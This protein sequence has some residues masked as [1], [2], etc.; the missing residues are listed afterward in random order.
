LLRLRVMRLAVLGSVLLLL[1]GCDSGMS[2]TGPPPA[3]PTPTAAPT[4]PPALRVATPFPTPTRAPVTPTPQAS[5][6]VYVAIGASDTVGVGATDPARE[7]WVPR[8]AGMLGP[9][10]RMVN[11]GVSGTVL[12]TAL[13]D[14][15]PRALRE[16]PDLVTVWL[17]VNDLNARVPLEA[18]TAD[19]DRLLGALEQ[20]GARVLIANV[21]DL[22]VVPIYQGQDT[23][24]LRAEIARWNSAIADL[25][26]KHKARV[27]DLYAEYE[28]LARNPTYISDDGFHPSSRGYA[29]IAELFYT[30][31]TS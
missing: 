31:A 10:T 21:P 2:R 7:G 16:Q 12:N 13:K 9:H 3:P 11:L 4:R 14:Q 27:V 24:P 8:L 17:A 28:E 1:L 18:Y 26:G 20:T 23:S 22:A 30:A 29:R 5:N 25:A 6:L 15:L 19:L